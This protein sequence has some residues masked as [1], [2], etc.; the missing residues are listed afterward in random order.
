MVRIMQIKT[1]LR[2]VFLVLLAVIILGTCGRIPLGGREENVRSERDYKRETTASG[3]GR[4]APEAAE[5]EVAEKELSAEG[6]AQEPGNEDVQLATVA[7]EARKP[8]ERKRVYSGYGSL[9]VDSVEEKKKEISTIAEESGGYVESVYEQTI[10]IRVPAADFDSLFQQI[11]S[12]GEV[13]ERSV[14]TIDVTEFFQDLSSR[15]EIAQRTRERLYRLLERTRDVEERLKILREIKRLT[16]EIEKIGL[17]LTLLEQRIAF[18]R[19]SIELVPRLEEEQTTRDRIPFPW[20]A[21]LDPLYITLDPLKRGVELDPGEEFAVFKP[22]FSLIKKAQ[23]YRAESA[24]GTRLRVSMTRNR[25]EGDSE[26]WQSALAHHLGV[27]YKEALPMELGGVRAVVLKSKD[28]TPFFYLVGIKQRRKYLY[29]I[30]VFYPNQAAYDNRRDGIES[31][32]KEFR[33]K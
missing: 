9:L 14:E 29:V 19:I 26:F 31:A 28:R 7:D 8:E 6:G 22:Q 30:E 10:I 33:V 11:L 25:P 4:S 2:A 12:L 3:S 24:D 23:Y 32:I 27:Y 15:L 21:D 1:I 16:E 13:L 18:S 5:S 17:T 20:I